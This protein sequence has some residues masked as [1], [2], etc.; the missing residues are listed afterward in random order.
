MSSRI[1]F[2]CV[3]TLPSH[4]HLTTVISLSHT[5][6]HTHTLSFSLA[7]LWVQVQCFA[8]LSCFSDCY[9]WFCLFYFYKFW[10]LKF[11]WLG[12]VGLA[13]IF[14]YWSFCCCWLIVIV[15]GF[16]GSIEGVFVW[17]WFGLWGY[18]LLECGLYLRCDFWCFRCLCK[19]Q[20]VRVL[21]GCSW[22]WLTLRVWLRLQGQDLVHWSL[23]GRDHSA[24]CIKGRCMILTLELVVMCPEKLNC[25]FMLCATECFLMWGYLSCFVCRWNIHNLFSFDTNLMLYTSSF[26]FDSEE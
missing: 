13:S 14:F 16:G 15:V 21:K 6:S 18:D 9:C 17:I 1:Q 20:C 8:A 7:L 4:F 5:H 25:L 10:A 23:L 22:E 24:M 2:C 3:V 11:G 26:S 19:G 12:V